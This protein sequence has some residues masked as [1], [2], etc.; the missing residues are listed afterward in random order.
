MQ[1]PPHTTNEIAVLVGRDVG[2]LRQ[3]GLSLDQA[4]RVV[5]ER[6]GIPMWRATQLLRQHRRAE[7]VRVE[8]QAA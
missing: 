7:Q 3:L 8:R 2:A 6:R 4:V 1:G 5:A